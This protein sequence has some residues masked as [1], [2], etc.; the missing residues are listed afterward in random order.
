MA[1]RYSSHWSI[2][3]GDLAYTSLVPVDRRDLVKTGWKPSPLP[4][5]VS[6]KGLEVGGK[7]ELS[8]S[9]PGPL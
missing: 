3:K 8:Q 6:G 9:S 1:Q 4:M 5:M 2:G 7:L